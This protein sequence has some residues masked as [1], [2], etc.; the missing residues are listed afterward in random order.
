MS[1]ICSHAG[2][3]ALADDASDSPVLVSVTDTLSTSASST[4]SVQLPTCDVGDLLIMMWS[5]NGLGI[6]PSAPAGWTSIY[7]ILTF[8]ATRV[9]YKIAVS[10]DSGSAVTVT[11]AAA[12]YG[13]VRVYRIAAGSFFSSQAPAIASATGSS[14][15]PNS[16]SL[17]PSWGTAKNLWLSLCAYA[18]L[19]VLI[20]YPLSDNQSA[21]HDNG[22]QR[23]NLGA[24]TLNSLAA[25][26]DPGAYAMS[27]S[28]SWVAA[29]VAVRPAA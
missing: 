3:I 29:T 20:S 21:V 6:Q 8:G 19:G 28:A 23:S 22:G 16:P 24:C 7:S 26:F 2:I 25:S 15:A 14:N 18:D 10:G 13:A 11:K 5:F 9:L 1:L 4:L 17:T 12:I 27:A